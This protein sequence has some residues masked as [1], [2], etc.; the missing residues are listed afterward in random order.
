M[1]IDPLDYHLRTRHAPFHPARGPGWLDWDNQPDPFR[2]FVGS[3]VVLLDREAGGPDPAYDAVLEGTLPAPAPVDWSSVSR[4]FFDALALSAWKEVGDTRWSLRVNPSSGNLHPTEAYLVAGPVSELAAE[5]AVWHYQPYL[6]GLEQRAVLSEATWR[7]LAG[8]LPPGAVLVGLSSILWREAWKYGERAFRYCQHDLGHA[9][10][11]LSLAAAGLGWRARLLD[12]VPE[13]A[14]GALLGTSEQVG[15]EAETAEALLAVY[16]EAPFPLAQWRHYRLPALPRLVW[17]GAPASLSA[18]HE[19]W[20]VIDAVVEATHHPGL[21]ASG[22]RIPPVR[23]PE[24]PTRPPSFRHLVRTRRSA[25]AMD[26]TTTLPRAAFLRTVHRLLPGAPPF[27]TLPWAPEVHPIFFVHRVEGLA[28]GVYA[29]PR[30]PSCGLREALRA[31]RTWEL[32]TPELPLVCLEAGDVRR[33]AQ[34]ISCDQEIA[35]DGAFAVA[36]LADLGGALARF[37]PSFYRRLHWEAGAIGQ[38]LYLEAESDGVRGTGIGC[39]YDDLALDAV[40]LVP[41][42]GWRSIYHFTTGGPVDD[43]RLRTVGA[44][45]HL[46]G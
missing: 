35:S 37:G 39:F 27:D 1:A 4:L 31:G 12:S 11:G 19:D 18:E 3:P 44:Y 40:G 24:G 29:L 26:G 14:L 2:R 23:L 9:I 34:S 13:G 28:P 5:A 15:A 8:D 17:Q 41:G 43:A 46:E 32:V 16:P 42:A 21:P 38:V 7:R 22:W 36:M 30:D 25:V 20:P 33:R 45:R 6:H 10:A